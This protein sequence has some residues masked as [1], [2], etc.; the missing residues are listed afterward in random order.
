M[1]EFIDRRRNE[2]RCRLCHE[3]HALCYMQ[4]RVG[5][6][7]FYDCPRTKQRVF[8]ARIDGLDIPTIESKALKKTHQP[9]PTQVQLG[10]F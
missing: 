5:V 8:T 7:M 2:A 1:S 4:M 9:P 6:A 3:M 10:L